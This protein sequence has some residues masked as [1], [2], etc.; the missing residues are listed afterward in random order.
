[1]VTALGG[2]PLKAYQSG[3]TYGKGGVESA[4]ETDLRAVPGKRTIEVNARGDVLGE[5][6]RADA[7]AGDDVWLSIDL[8]LQAHAERLIAAKIRSLRGSNAAD[9]K[10]N[11]R[12]GSVVILQPGTG[13][14]LAMASYPT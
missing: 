13:Q 12:Q 5:V 11:A 9:G 1:M 14:V 4:Y 2:E 8:D 7:V 6:D 10:L 3:D